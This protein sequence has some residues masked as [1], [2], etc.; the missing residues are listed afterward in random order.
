MNKAEKII[1]LVKEAMAQMPAQSQQSPQRSS[2]NVQFDSQT[3]NPF[4]AT[5]SQRGFS[6]DGTRL[7]FETLED[8]ISKEYTITLKN[9]LVLDAVRMQKIL[10]YK[11]LY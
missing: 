4:I 3:A 5:F 11:T 10:K 6:I 8:A 1:T 9:G 7:S 2:T